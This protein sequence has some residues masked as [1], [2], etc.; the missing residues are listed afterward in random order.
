MFRTRKDSGPA[1]GT[2][3]SIVEPPHNELGVSAYHRLGSAAIRAATDQFYNRVQSDTSLAE[4]F[5]LDRMDH[6]K[7]H[8]P[9]LIGQLLGGPVKYAN[10]VEILRDAHQPLGIS[11]FAYSLLCAHL[12]TILYGL[13]VPHDIR[14][15]LMA[16]L[17][18]VEDLII[19][20]QL[21][22]VPA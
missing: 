9:L 2:Y 5:P 13:R 1:P 16:Q 19:A 14:I 20:E 21:Q 12:N 4:F 22:P 7:R 6:L 10:P 11:P 3:V 17:I 18:K 15:F 8:L